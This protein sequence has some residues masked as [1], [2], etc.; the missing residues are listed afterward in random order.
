MEFD[1]D[2]SIP[3]ENYTGTMD[4]KGDGHCGFRIMALLLTG[5]ESN[6]PAIKKAM[7]DQ[8][9]EN[10]AIYQYCFNLPVEEIYRILRVPSDRPCGIEGWF[11]AAYCCQLASDAFGVPIA[12][13][14][15]AT[16]M[17]PNSDADPVT[18]PMFDPVLYLPIDG[19]KSKEF[20]K[21]YSQVS[22]DKNCRPHPLLLHHVG[23]VHWASVVLKKSRKMVWP[24][25]NYKHYEACK[26]LQKPDRVKSYWK[27]HLLIQKRAPQQVNK[28]DLIAIP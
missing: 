18:M 16:R 5:D 2:M 22:L 6:F 15:N 21:L 19:P 7:L 27:Y 13:Y 28:D 25:V 8:L 24:P 4:V 26:T 14:S 1:V 11:D 17:D 10:K 3:R 20:Y 9:D 12:V 23:G